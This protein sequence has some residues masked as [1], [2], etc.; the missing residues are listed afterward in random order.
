[1]IYKNNPEQITTALLLAAG[2]GSRLRPLTGKLPKCLTQV[3]EIE[4]LGRL[5]TNLQQ[6][7]FKKLIVVVGYLEEHIKSYL[8]IHAGDITVEYVT[9]PIFSTTN[10]IYSLWLAKD[11]IKEPFMLIESDL[12]FEA[13]LLEGMLVPDKIAVSRILPWMN[14]T[15]VTSDKSLVNLVT[16]INLDQQANVDDNLYKTVNIYSFSMDSWNKIVTE[17]DQWIDE[18]KVCEYYEAVFSQMVD[19]N[20]LDLSC[21]YFDLNQWYEIDTIEDLHE[22]EKVLQ[23]KGFPTQLIA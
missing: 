15:T 18:G 17:L 22:C 20:L 4:I 2:T 14:G 6:N 1:M 8:A 21:V 7:G 12:V 11:L 5:V 23:D 13:S 10:N 16:S 19:E 3:N 9:N